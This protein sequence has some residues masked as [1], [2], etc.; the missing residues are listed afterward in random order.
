MASGTLALKPTALP[1][2]RVALFRIFC[3]ASESV[4]DLFSFELML[5]IGMSL[6]MNQFVR[7]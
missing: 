7:I 6:T 1:S 2:E 5:I 3:L 4:L